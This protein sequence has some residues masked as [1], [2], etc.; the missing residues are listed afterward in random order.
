[1]GKYNAVVMGEFGLKLGLAQFNFAISRVSVSVS[2]QCSG[3][4][5]FFTGKFGRTQQREQQRQQQQ[6][7][8]PSRQ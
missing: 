2:V 6:Q 8:Q 3:S 7:Q 4:M 5:H 1:M